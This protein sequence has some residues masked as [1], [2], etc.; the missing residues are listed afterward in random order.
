MCLCNLLFQGEDT[1]DSK[2]KET[3][4]PHFKAGT[5]NALIFCPFSLVVLMQSGFS[6]VEMRDKVQPYCLVGEGNV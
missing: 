5:V 3:D 1:T 2:L 6:E 4:F